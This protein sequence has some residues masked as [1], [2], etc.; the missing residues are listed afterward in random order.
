VSIELIIRDLL[1]HNQQLVIP[2]FGTFRV[3]HRPAQISKTTQLLMPPT[4]EIVFDTRHTKGDTL[5]QLSIRKKLG[6]S[7][8]SSGEAL[9]K[10]LSQL[11]EEMKS[12]GTAT[13]EGLG[14]ISRDKSGNLKFEPLDDLLNLTGEFALP[15]LEIKVPGPV[16]KIRSTPVQEDVP[17]TI[18]EIP[19]IRERRKW[20]IPAAIVLALT[21]L[22]SVAYFTGIFRSSGKEKPAK[23]PTVSEAENPDRLVFGSREPAERDSIAEDSMTD[24]IR[25]Q[26]EERIARENALRPEKPAPKIGPG[27]ATPHAKPAGAPL[28]AGPGQYHII[29]GSFTVPGNAE[30][31]VSQLRNKGLSPELLPRRGKYIM[32]SLGSYVSKNE[33]VSA[34]NQLRAKLE[35]DLW[36]MRVE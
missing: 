18:P 24:I 2:G 34:M 7:E 1:L 36:V 4:K 29:S 35:Q 21:V 22:A 26:L 31:Q 9:E 23:E 15:E 25:R 13:I 28:S 27:T 14:K 8:S 19:E 12:D 16:E 5:L 32:V 3:I 11:E 33:A 10:F 6:L 17:E 30:K 20:W